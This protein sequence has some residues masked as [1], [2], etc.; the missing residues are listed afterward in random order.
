MKSF[1]QITSLPASTTSMY[2]SFVVDIEMNLY[3]LDCHDTAHHT[4]VMM[5]PD[6]DRLV[7]TSVDLSESIKPSNMELP[8][9]NQRHMVEMP[10]R[11][12]TIHLIVA[13]CS[14]PELL[15]YRLTTPTTYPMS[16]LVQTI[17]YIRLLTIE[18]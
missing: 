1:I 10:F 8:E 14:L 12:R 13:Q 6:V 5:Y 7:S 3:S 16:D 4:Y 9:S 17:I 18:A 2:S 15:M 11:H